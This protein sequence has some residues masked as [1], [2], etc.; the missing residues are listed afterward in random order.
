MGREMESEI[1]LSLELSIGGC[2]AKSES[3]TS[4]EREKGS[5]SDEIENAQNDA[6]AESGCDLQRRREMQAMKRREARMKREFKKSRGVMMNGCRQDKVEEEREREGAAP[7]PKREKSS[8]ASSFRENK[9][10]WGLSTPIGNG[11]AC[12][13]VG[14]GGDPNHGQQPPPS[15]SHHRSTSHKGGSSSDTGSHSSSFGTHQNDSSSTT[16]QSDAEPACQFQDQSMKAS[17]IQRP[18]SDTTCSTTD[19]INPPPKVVSNPGRDGAASTLQMPCVSA[20][21][22]GPNG[23]TITGFL[24]KYTK[25]E[26]SIMCVC[27]GSFFSP[28]KFVEHAGGVDVTH[29]LRHITIV[30]SAIR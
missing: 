23:R 6:A 16:R 3:K 5:L 27:H 21:G 10:S 17:S 19:V 8:N 14:E 30:S 29:P 15:S 7:V 28:A 18:Q 26:V 9:V 12:P 20:T 24:Y 13:S 11:F 2:Y 22:N 25:S 1:E 4:L